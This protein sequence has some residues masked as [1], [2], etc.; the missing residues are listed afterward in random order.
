M[1]NSLD[2]K[3]KRCIISC[4]G[5]VRI[6]GKKSVCLNLNEMIIIPTHKK[7]NKLNSETIEQE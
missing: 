5:H 4:S 7:N 6:F 2:M 3:E 1:L